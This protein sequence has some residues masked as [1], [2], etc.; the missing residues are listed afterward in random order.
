MYAAPSSP[1]WTRKKAISAPSPFKSNELEQVHFAMGLPGLRYH[2]DDFYASQ[3]MSTV[4][5][6][7]MSSRLVQE[8]RERRGLA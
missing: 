6:G 1:K 2:D 5:G 7:G 4:L 8:I 3:V